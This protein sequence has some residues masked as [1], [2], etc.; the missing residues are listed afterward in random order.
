M[1][2]HLMKTVL[3]Y[4]NVFI[5]LKGIF[6]ILSPLSIVEDTILDFDLYFKVIFGEFLQMYE[7]SDNTMKARTIDDIALGPNGNL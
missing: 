1:V 2:V 4:I 5:W 6:Q 7:G 3:F